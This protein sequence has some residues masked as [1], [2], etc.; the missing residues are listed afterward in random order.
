MTINEHDGFDGLDEKNRIYAAADYGDDESGGDG[1]EGNDLFDDGDEEEEVVVTMSL[2]G[3]AALDLLEDVA[4][5]LLEAGPHG[6]AAPPPPVAV[7]APAIATAKTAEIAKEAAEKE[8][9]AKQAAAKKAAAK[10]AA[11][12]KAVAKKKKVAKKAPW[13]HRV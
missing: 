8:A 2:E 4:D 13:S 10:K 11:A 12:K 5:D 9:A 1:Y 6:E 7:P 3:D